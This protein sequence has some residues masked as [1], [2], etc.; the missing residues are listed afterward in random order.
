MSLIFY[1]GQLVKCF[2][3]A[4]P[5]AANPFY[6]LSTRKSRL[7]NAF[8]TAKDPEIR[9]ADDLFPG[10]LVGGFVAKEEE[11]GEEGEEKW[12]EPIDCDRAH[13][14]QLAFYA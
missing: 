5:T 1:E 11:E 2:V 6:S 8:H 10:S 13:S 7:K 9:A 14:F 3:K 12:M 4:P